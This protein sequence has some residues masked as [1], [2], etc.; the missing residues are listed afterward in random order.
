MDSCMPGIRHFKHCLAISLLCCLS[1]IIVL[2]P[3][4]STASHHFGEAPSLAAAVQRGALPPAE[5]RLPTL[6]MFVQPFET[7]GEYGGVWRMGLRGDRDH[8]LLLRTL[9]YENLVRWSPS[10]QQVLPNIAHRVTPNE[11]YS[12]YTFHL[13]PGMRWSDGAPF[14]ADDILFWYEA[15]FS[16]VALTPVKPAWLV[17]NGQPVEVEKINDVTVAFRFAAPNGLFL[18]HLAHPLGAEPT[19]YPKHYLERFHPDYQPEAVEQAMQTEKLDSWTAL[20]ISKCGA[21]GSIDHPSRWRH[22]ELPTLNAWVLDQGY[23]PKAT[24]LTASRN[25]YYWKIDPSGSQLPYIDQ[26]HFMVGD[27]IQLEAWAADG[28]LDMQNRHLASEALRET[29]AASSKRGGYTFFRTVP[30][31]SSSHV[32]M[33]N[34]T[35]KDPVL[36][37]LFQ[38][39]RFREAM[40]LAINRA[41]RAIASTGA[42][43]PPY[44]AAPRPESSLYNEKLATQYTAYA[45][46]RANQLLDELGCPR[47]ADGVRRRPDGA[48]LRLVLSTEASYTEIFTPLAAMWR[49][50][51]VEV[52][53]EGLART[54]LYARLRNNDHDLSTAA[55]EGGLDVLLEHQHY[56]PTHESSFFAVGWRQWLQT[57]SSPLAQRP[58]DAVLRQA[59]LYQQL[60]AQGDQTEQSRLMREILD[61][62]ADLFF[63]M[64]LYL[65]QDSFG[66]VSQRMRNV[67]KVMPNAWSYPTPAPTNPCQYYFTTAAP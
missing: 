61:I 43:A 6:P 39:I 31:H 3:S 25:P 37:A 51:G 57:P 13:R 33:L 48:P 11:D 53:V 46:E 47:G 34:L 12:A 36:R 20:F 41:A 26:L 65:E 62:A 23:S 28:F 27:Q 19:S 29:F 16:N 10:W 15:V 7:L 2:I 40:S 22:P 9:G 67:P 58:P 44:Q 45:P 66:I 59:A 17:N 30:A 42:P 55:G 5:F 49:E 4:F 35:H 18:Q 14:T 50:V 21:P 38:D 1:L 60:K 63:V 64:G 24:E 8:A 54:A 56:L 32:F 52:Q